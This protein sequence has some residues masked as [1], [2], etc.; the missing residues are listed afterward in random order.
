MRRYLLTLWAVM[1]AAILVLMLSRGAVAA[2]V[3]QDQPQPEA[4]KASL[5]M[6]HL[7]GASAPSLTYAE[8]MAVLSSVQQAY[9]AMPGDD[10]VAERKALADEILT[11][12]HVE[13]SGVEAD[14]SVWGRFTD[15]RLFV[16]APTPREPV[17]TTVAAAEAAPF[18]LADNE[19]PGKDKV[20]V[21]NALGTCFVSEANQLSKLLVDKK[22]VDSGVTPSVDNLKKSAMRRYSILTRMAGLSK[23]RQILQ[24]IVYGLQR[25]SARQTRLRMPRI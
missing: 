8:R 22:Y 2:P 11:L 17:T 7:Q 10:L 9:D 12:P 21:L 13:A 20:Y 3:R 16:V 23:V 6:P 1:A 24:S 19:L 4:P 15:Q 18:A 25:S 5:Y 14:G